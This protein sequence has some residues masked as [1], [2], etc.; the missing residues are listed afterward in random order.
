LALRMYIREA[1]QLQ[2]ILHVILGAIPA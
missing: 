1:A 2:R